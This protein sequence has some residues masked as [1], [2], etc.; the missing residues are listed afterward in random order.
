MTHVSRKGRGRRRRRLS[1]SS[2]GAVPTHCSFQKCLRST[3]CADT[4]WLPGENRARL[5]PQSRQQEVQ[6]G[7]GRLQG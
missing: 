3:V 2:P 1:L 6:A 7:R 4:A 5:D